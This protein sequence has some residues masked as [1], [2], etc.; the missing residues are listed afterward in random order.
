VFATS[1]EP[2]IVEQ[3]ALEDVEGLTAVSEIARMIVVQVWGIVIHFE[4]GFPKKDE[5]PVC[6]NP[7]LAKCG[8]EAQH[9]ER[10]RIWSPPG[11]PNV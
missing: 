2:E 8:G 3:E 5:R 11:L 7:T 6:C 4:D 1:L 9:L 10:L